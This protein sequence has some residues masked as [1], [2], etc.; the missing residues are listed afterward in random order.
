MM[1]NVMQCCS[2]VFPRWL[3]PVVLLVE[4]QGRVG[5]ETKPIDG[6]GKVDLGSGVAE[7]NAGASGG[8]AHRFSGISFHVVEIQRGKD[9]RLL[10]LKLTAENI[11][12]VSLWFNVHPVTVDTGLPKERQLFMSLQGPWRRRQ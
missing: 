11:D 2:N 9:A 1:V 5:A 4:M 6:R 8:V 10:R 12:H 3:V 7:C